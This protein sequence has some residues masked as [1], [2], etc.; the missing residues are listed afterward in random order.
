MFKILTNKINLIFKVFEFD[1]YKIRSITSRF[2][3]TD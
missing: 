1:E 3:E 2:L